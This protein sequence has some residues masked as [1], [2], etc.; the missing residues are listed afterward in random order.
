MKV[1]VIGSGGREHALIWKIARSKLV[2]K[3]YCANGNG[4]IGNLAECVPIKPDDIEGLRN[5]ALEQS[6]DL[7]VVGPEQP[8]TMGIVDEFESK[9]LKIFG[10]SAMAAEIEG[11]KVFSKYLMQKYDIP[12]ADFKVFTE[13]HDAKEYLR[14]KNKPCVVKA[15]GLAAGKGAVVCRKLAEALDAVEFMMSDHAFG[16]AGDRVVIEEFMEGEEASVFVI[17]DGTD[18]LVLPVAQD[19]KRALD[20]DRGKNTGGMGAY[21][22]A[23]VMTPDLLQ[24]AIASIVKPTIAA[25]AKEGRSYKGVLYCGLMVTSDGPKV[26]EYNC[27][28][29]DPECQVVMPL[30]ESDVVEMFIAA[31]DG[32]IK[33]YSLTLSDRH[34]TCVVLASGGYPEAY[35]KNKVIHGLDLA[36]GEGIMVFHA[37]THRKDDQF[38][39][40]GGRVLGVTAV[41][42]DLGEAVEKAYGAVAKIR[43]DKAHYRKDIGS[44]AL[45]KVPGK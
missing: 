4:G 28:F 14:E 9:G 22:P 16:S 7:T 45:K 41:G 21:A 18:F 36:G 12:T 3:L 24:A 34:A 17:T 38:L 11:S 35:E 37:G 44:K 13:V 20:G 1:L 27:R 39:T 31:C 43:F 5:F 40:N 26:V 42:A 30:I 33:D 6:I 29:G 15:D 19:H 8:L 23:P 25:M 2:S 32:K 10:P